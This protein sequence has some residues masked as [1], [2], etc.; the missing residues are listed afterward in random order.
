MMCKQSIGSH[1]VCI[2]MYVCM[3]IYIKI[4]IYIYILL[5]RVHRTL[6][7]MIYTHTHDTYIP[8]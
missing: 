5:I 7:A 4:T 3:Y 8:I 6:E 1:D 2:C